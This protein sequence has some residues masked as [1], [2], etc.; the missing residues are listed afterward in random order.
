MLN[1]SFADKEGEDRTRSPLP[2]YFLTCFLLSHTSHIEKL[3]RR[4]HPNAQLLCLGQFAAGLL[5]ADQIIGL[6]AHRTAGH[7][8]QRGDQAVHLIAGIRGSTLPVT[9]NVLPG[10]W[11]VLADCLIV[12]AAGFWM[13]III[14]NS[15]QIQK[16]SSLQNHSWILLCSVSPKSGSWR[17]S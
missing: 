14:C 8:A 2:C 15:S 10:K 1:I 6:A 16:F 3:I 4:Q 13:F 17:K 12:G 9:H 5:T 7:S 11:S